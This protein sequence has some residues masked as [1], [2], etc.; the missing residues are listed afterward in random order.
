MSLNS[1]NTNDKNEIENNLIDSSIDDAR[2]LLGGVAML[3]FLVM[4]FGL[5]AS[6]LTV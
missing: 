4:G 1:E 6:T 3:G 5:L 2:W